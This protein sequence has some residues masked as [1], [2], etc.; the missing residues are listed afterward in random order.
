MFCYRSRMRRIF[1]QLTLLC[2]GLFVSPLSAQE[3]T[4]TYRVTA[5][6]HLHLIVS[7]DHPK[8]SRGETVYENRRKNQS[9]VAEVPGTVT[10]PQVIDMPT[11]TF[12]SSMKKL[13]ASRDVEV[14]G[15]IAENGDFID[16]VISDKVK[17]DA[18]DAVTE[19]LVKY[20]FQPATLDGK[21][22]AFLTGIV[23]KFR[24]R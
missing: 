22:V 11:P 17:P 2:A 14:T 24:F 18:K 6:P 3:P 12:P 20:R 7:V 10:L 8:D 13:F 19:V 15:V 5:L 16:P 21:P 23:F 9:S 1:I 4:S